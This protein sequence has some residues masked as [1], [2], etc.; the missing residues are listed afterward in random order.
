MLDRNSPVRETELAALWCYVQCNLTAH[1]KYRHSVTASCFTYDVID[2][3]TFRPQSG[4]FQLRMSANRDLLLSAAAPAGLAIQITG[5]PGAG[6]IG[7][8][9]T[10]CCD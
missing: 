2:D 5:R 8:R 3:D 10:F 7:K 1:L 6:V 4:S 9:V